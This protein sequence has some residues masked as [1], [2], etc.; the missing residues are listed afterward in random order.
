MQMKPNF[1]KPTSY[2]PMTGRSR[3][4]NADVEKVVAR[5][6]ASQITKHRE[7]FDVLSRDVSGLE[8]KSVAANKTGNKVDVK[9]RVGGRAKTLHLCT[10]E[11]SNSRSRT[12]ATVAE[13]ALRQILEG[14]GAD[15]KPCSDWNLRVVN[16]IQKDASE[17]LKGKT[18]GWF[19]L[20]NHDVECFVVRHVF[21]LYAQK[22]LE[23]V[24]AAYQDYMAKGGVA[25]NRNAH[26]TKRAMDAV[27]N[28]AAHAFEHGA[29]IEDIV[30]AVRETLVKGVLES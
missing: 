18:E 23:R 8:V 19:H 28:A 17:T 27:R 25:Q 5:E 13:E 7:C 16:L 4:A 10:E 11:Y 26:Q 29:D 6:M 22:G 24:F 14:T 12:A 21:A 9:V 2:S 20:A 1:M 15:G 3:G 30:T